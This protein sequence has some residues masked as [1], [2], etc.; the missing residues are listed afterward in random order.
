MKNKVSLATVE[1]FKNLNTD[2]DRFVTVDEKTIRR[3]Q[4]ILL[5][6]GNDIISFCEEN[7]IDYFLCGGTTLGAVREEG[8]IA[9]DDD[10]DIAIPAKD[11]DHFLDLFAWE[12]P[13]K[14]TVQSWKDEDYGMTIGRI[15]MKSSVCRSRE[16]YGAKECGFYI[17]LFKVEN[18]FNNTFLRTMHGILCM[19]CGLLLS[20]RNFYQ[21][22]VL[23]RELEKDNPEVRKV[24]ECKILI[25]KLLSFLSVRR[26]AMITAGVY[27]LCKNDRSIYV[28]IPSGRKHYFEEMYLRDG[29]CVTKKQRFEQY[30]W[31]IPS[32]HDSYLKKLYGDYMRIPEEEEKE[33][34]LILELVFPEDSK[35]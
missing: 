6:M 35:E 16:D 7:G 18:T 17:D 5:E 26:W 14:Y 9:W 24:F 10:M 12:Y 15:R 11:F 2:S 23:M 27:G 1:L 22:R 25:G 13:E 29:L 30:L 34:H 20:C 33:R 31:N 8:F 21:N 4:K 3:I 28:S 32:D 19:G